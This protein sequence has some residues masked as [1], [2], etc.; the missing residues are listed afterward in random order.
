MQYGVDTAGIVRLGGLRIASE[1]RDLGVRYQPSEPAAVR[2]L[3][4]ALAI[5]HS[6]Y[7]FV[8]YGSGKGRVLLVASEFP[9]KRIVG[10]EF[11]PELNQIARENLARFPRDRQRCS[12]IELVTVDAAEYEL[13]AEPAVLYFYNPFA[14]P[15]LRRV[16]TGVQESLGS[17]PRP[18]L[19]LFT[20]NLPRAELL[21]D[22]GLVRVEA[23]SAGLGRAI[24]AAGTPGEAR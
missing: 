2:E 11:S 22:A 13:P 15:V 6:E 9:F 12:E 10:V 19:L 20:G 5:D 14:E 23:A 16:L 24:F 3:I 18:V 4:D 7:V 21:E 17:H 1:N 8:D